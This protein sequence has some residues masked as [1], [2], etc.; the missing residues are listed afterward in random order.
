ML[1]AVGCAPWAKLMPSWG[2]LGRILWP[3]GSPLG[4][5]WAMSGPSWGHFGR[6]WGLL[7][8][9][10]G[11]DHQAWKAHTFWRAL[12][13]HVFADFAYKTNGF[14]MV[15]KWH[16]SP[17]IKITYLLEMPKSL[18]LGPCAAKSLFSANTN[19]K[20]LIAVSQKCL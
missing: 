15:L 10:L 9:T 14:L 16:C 20:R 12:L 6:S 2:Y 5:S 8:S 4:L 1:Y 19:A 13:E 7:G 11:L 17:N 3:L 18:S